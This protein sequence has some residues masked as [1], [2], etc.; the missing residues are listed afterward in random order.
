MS[1]RLSCFNAYDVRGRIPDQ[2][3][4]DIACRIARAYADFLAPAEVVLGHDVRLSSPAIA[5]AIARGLMAEGVSVQHLGLAGTEEVYFAVANGGFDGG[6]MVTASHNPIDYNGIK[7]VRQNARP[8]SQD[9]GLGD[10]QE[11]AEKNRFTEAGQKGELRQLQNRD[12][13]TEHLLSYVQPEN[14]KPLKI[15]VNPGHGGAGPVIDALEKHLPFEFIKIH[16]EPDGSFPKGVPNPLIPENQ[17]PTMEAVRASG[18]DLGLAW[19]GDFDRCFLFDAEGNFI[20][21]YYVVGLLAEV[22]LKRAPGS[23]VIHD[24]RLTWNTL[25][26]V[27]SLGGEAVSSRTGHSFMK[28]KMR[29]VDAVYGGEVSAHHYFRSFSFCDSGM[30]PWLL[31]AQLMSDEGRPL[32]ELVRDRQQLFPASGEINRRIADPDAAIKKVRQDYQ[33][34]ALSIDESDGLSMEFADW[35]FSLRKSNTEPMTRLNVESRGSRELMQ[36]HTRALLNLLENPD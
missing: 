1:E 10:I 4:E 28:E 36:S 17:G 30:I 29:E 6:I 11:L 12:A 22:F 33:R 27:K 35:R 21:G 19:D 34:D 7:L 15:L 3:N 16:H 2:L 25:D 23:K 9:T 5:D 26:I 8:I 32:A 18:A 13:Y 20:N 24:Q 31:V 14:L